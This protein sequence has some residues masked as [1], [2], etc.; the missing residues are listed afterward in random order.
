MDT[1]D[2]KLQIRILLER[3]KISIAKLSRMVDLSSG[4]VYNY[5]K[6]IS[7]ISAANLAKLF[8]AL[9]SVKEKGKG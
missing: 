2:F 3:K 1:V 7:E 6:G 9:N 4:T 8:N 5:L